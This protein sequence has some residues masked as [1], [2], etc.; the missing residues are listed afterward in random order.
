MI[1]M[2]DCRLSSYFEHQVPSPAWRMVA[3]LLYS[4]DHLQPSWV[5]SIDRHLCLPADDNNNRFSGSA[6][7]CRTEPLGLWK[8]VVAVCFQ[9]AAPDRAADRLRR[10]SRTLASTL[11]WS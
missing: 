3:Q 5:A 1:V 8:M 2:S 11:R 6:V 10:R 4:R 9:R 7:K